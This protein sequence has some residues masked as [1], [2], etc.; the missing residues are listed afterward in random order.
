MKDSKV[1]SA[2]FM[3]NEISATL[4]LPFD[5]IKKKGLDNPECV[6]AEETDEGILIHRILDKSLVCGINA[7]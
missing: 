2:I 7:S 1:I 6:I 4:I 5:A 3:V